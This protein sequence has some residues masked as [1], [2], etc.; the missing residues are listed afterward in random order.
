MGD[1]F[2]SGKISK[3]STAI[4]SFGSNPTIEAKV[5]NISVK[6]ISALDVDASGITPGHRAKNGS[7]CPASQETDFKSL[8][9]PAEL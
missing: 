1:P 4:E 5:E 6:E 3:L 9:I 8:K 2:K 7:Q